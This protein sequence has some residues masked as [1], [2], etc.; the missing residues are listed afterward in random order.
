VY[1]GWFHS[2]H[3]FSS[4]NNP[5]YLYSVRETRRVVNERDG[6]VQ[7][8]RWCAGCHDPV[9]F[10][11]GAFDR[12]DYD[13]VNDATSQAG[14]TC[15]VC[16]A[17]THVE[18]NRG[19]ANYVIEEPIQ[20]PFTYSDH[21]ILK[22]VNSLLVKAK[23]GFHK[24]TFL[25]SFHKTEE[26]C[27]VCHKVHLPK[28]VTNYKDFVRGQDHYGS[29]LLS[30]VSGHGAQ[31][32]YYP[33]RAQDNCNGCHMPEMESKD[34]GAKPSPQTGQIVIHDHFFPG[35]NTALP[36]W[37]GEDETVEKARQL[38]KGTTRL[39]LFGIREGGSIDGQLIAPLGQKLPTL[40]AGQRYLIETVIRTLKLGH[41][42]TQGTVDSNELWIELTVRSGDRVLG[43][44]GG[45]DEV[46]K[47]DEWSHF[48]NVF[49]LDRK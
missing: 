43:I 46:G 16:H 24:Q 35:A 27:S 40:V 29:F 8:S 42:L 23:P 37:R 12:P 19:N 15:T 1:Q 48:V 7:A 36:W 9:P 39:D 45:M 31:S 38:L 21:P 32:F 3:H 13:D 28:E 4:F 22:E 26:F 25:K 6:T 47:V 34:F 10:F 2:A 49:M 30:G 44:S 20:Y 11:T 17:I 33:P 5:A 18:S 14:I 41:H